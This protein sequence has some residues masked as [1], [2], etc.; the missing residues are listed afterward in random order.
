MHTRGTHDGHKLARIEVGRDSTNDFFLCLV[1]LEH[2]TATAMLEISIV[3]LSPLPVL[4]LKLL[5]AVDKLW[6]G[7]EIQM[8][9]SVWQ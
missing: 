9:Q 6:P 7:G 4:L 5:Y 3:G 2:A 8:S 1:I